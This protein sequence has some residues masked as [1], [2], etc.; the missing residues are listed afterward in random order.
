M[1]S[2][3]IYIDTTDAPASVDKVKYLMSQTLDHWRQADIQI[4]VNVKMLTI[5]LSSTLIAYMRHHS[6]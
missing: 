3:D 6:R 2:L 4:Q 5:V 1:K